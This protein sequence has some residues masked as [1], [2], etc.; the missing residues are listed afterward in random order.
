MR[1]YSPKDLQ[2]R[3]IERRAVEAVS[4]GMPAVNFERMLQAMID[5]LK[6]IGIAKDKRFAPDASTK[7]LLKSAI[8]EAHA[9]MDSIYNEEFFPAFAKGSRWALPASPDVAEAIQTDFVASDSY[10]IDSRGRAYSYVFFSAKHLGA[11]QYYLMTIK[12]KAGRSFDGSENYRLTVPA[13]APVSS[14]GPRPC[15]TALRRR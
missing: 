8:L 3:A 1:S 5:V 9:W 10:P 4:W 14:T 7:R 15:T 13:N 2:R 11:G 12:D 6:T